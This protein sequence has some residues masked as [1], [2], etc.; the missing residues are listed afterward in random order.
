MQCARLTVTQLRALLRG[1]NDD[2]EPLSVSWL[3]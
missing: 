3:T 1:S 2:D